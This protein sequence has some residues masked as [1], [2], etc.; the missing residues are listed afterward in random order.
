M[1]RDDDVKNEIEVFIAI[2][3]SRKNGIKN[4]IQEY[5]P[6]PGRIHH[7]HR[8]DEEQITHSVKLWRESKLFS[9]AACG[10]VFQSGRKSNTAVIF[11]K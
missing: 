10:L 8:T 6:S 7:V 11:E 5:E 3:E 9:M 1:K 4:P 2:R